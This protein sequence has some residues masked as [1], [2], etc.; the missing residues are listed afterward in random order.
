MDESKEQLWSHHLETELHVSPGCSSVAAPSG[1]G[2]CTHSAHVV[3][4]TSIYTVTLLG[5]VF[6]FRDNFREKTWF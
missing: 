3:G 2:W 5:L 6:F 4:F 1:C